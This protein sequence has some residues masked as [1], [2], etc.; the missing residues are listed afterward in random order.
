MMFNT[1]Q[2]KGKI[3][4]NLKIIV[5]KLEEKELELAIREEDRSVWMT[6]NEISQLYDVTTSY[7]SRLIKNR[8]SNQSTN[9]R[10][11]FPICQQ[12]SLKN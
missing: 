8:L 10:N 1:I 12:M 9:Y 3:M 4:K 11:K 2:K 6:Q 5:F 7:V